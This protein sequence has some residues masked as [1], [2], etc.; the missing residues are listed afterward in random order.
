MVVDSS[1][2]GIRLLEISVPDESLEPV[3]LSPCVFRVNNH[4]EAIL[5]VDPVH[6]GIIHLQTEAVCHCGKSHCYELVHCFIHQH[7][8]HL[9]SIWRPLQG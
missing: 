6:A 4:R 9:H 3:V 7:C 8:G 1:D 2:A 5:K